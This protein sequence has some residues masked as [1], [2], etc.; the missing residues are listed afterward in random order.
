MTWTAVTQ[1]NYSDF[2]TRLATQEQRLA[3]MGINYNHETVTQ[4]GSWGPLGSDHS[5]LY[6]G[7]L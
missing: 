5:H 7:N 2:I 6:D 4:I 1:K 3:Q